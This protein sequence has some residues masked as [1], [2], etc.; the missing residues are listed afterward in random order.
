MAK[1]P[2]NNVGVN[3]FSDRAMSAGRKAM[4][5][6]NPS[7]QV[8]VDQPEKASPGANLKRSKQTV[9]PTMTKPAVGASN[10]NRVNPMQAPG[11]GANKRNTKG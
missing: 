7:V 1:D 8:K 10:P 2:N 5:G 3:Q 4:G 6:S 11:V 9:L